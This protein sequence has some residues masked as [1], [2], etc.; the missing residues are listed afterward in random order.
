MRGGGG[1]TRAGD[2]RGRHAAEVVARCRSG[3]PEASAGSRPLSKREVLPW[4]F[5][6]YFLF[7]HS[8]SPMKTNSLHL[9]SRGPPRAV[10]TLSAETYRRDSGQ[11][12]LCVRA[13]VRARVH[14][15]SPQWDG[16]PSP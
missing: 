7:T 16:G 15:C 14:A 8:S 11:L 10:R 12:G 5:L 9:E 13:R 6:N 2:E 4:I 1:V 3:V